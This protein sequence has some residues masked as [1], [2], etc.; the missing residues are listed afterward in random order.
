MMI[1]LIFHTAII[2]NRKNWRVTVKLHFENLSI[3]FFKKRTYTQARTPPTPCRGI[4]AHLQHWVKKSRALIKWQCPNKHRIFSASLK[5]F[6]SGKLK[7]NIL[8]L[9]YN[10]S[11]FQWSFQKL[12]C[13]RNWIWPNAYEITKGI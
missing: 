1:C 3:F 6:F 9:D 2:I 10:M 8:D 5:L 4:I 7:E 11:H 12:A 13:D